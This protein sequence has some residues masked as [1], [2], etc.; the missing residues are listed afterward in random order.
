MQWNY[1]D[2]VWLTILYH[3]KL[4]LILGKVSYLYDKIESNDVEQ[5]I[6]NFIQNHPT[7]LMVMVAHPLNTSEL[8]VID[9]SCV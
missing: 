5:R 1:S 4:G 8:L 2:S 7:D 6:L 3:Q 9:L